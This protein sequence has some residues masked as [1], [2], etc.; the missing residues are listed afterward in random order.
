MYE[1]RYNEVLDEHLEYGP[2]GASYIEIWSYE[3][4]QIA[5]LSSD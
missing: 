1:R 3:V 4:C 2:G 5:H